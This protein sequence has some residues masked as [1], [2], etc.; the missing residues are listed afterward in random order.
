MTQYKLQSRIKE[1]E[2]W[3]DLNHRLDS[4]T[5]LPKTYSEQEA[6]AIIKQLM[7]RQ[8]KCLVNL[9]DI[10]LRKLEENPRLTPEDLKEFNTIYEIRKVPADE[11]I[12]AQR[13]GGKI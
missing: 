10:R 12:L 4:E 13:R 9:R 7:N 11:S 3:K 1:T 6:D 8:R 2:P 5:L